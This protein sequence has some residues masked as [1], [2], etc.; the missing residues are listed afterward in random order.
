MYV[1]HTPC[2]PAALDGRAC[3]SQSMSHGGKASAGPDAEQ[4]TAGDTDATQACEWDVRKRPWPMADGPFQDSARGTA[5]AGG[6][7]CGYWAWEASAHSAGDR[8]VSDP[9]TRLRRLGRKRSD[10]RGLIGERS[11]RSGR[12]FPTSACRTSNT[13]MHSTAYSTCA[14]FSSSFCTLLRALG[15][16]GDIA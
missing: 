15:R 7:L 1:W 5:T 4:Q 16:H 6:D 2:C 13:S 10:V 11:R 3:T 8:P 14:R 9:N 12:P